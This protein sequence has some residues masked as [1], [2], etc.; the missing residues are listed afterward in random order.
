MK[1]LGLII[2]VS[3]GLSA[4]ASGMNGGTMPGN[5]N[6]IVTQYPIEA[7]M[8][9][10]YTKARSQSLVA[11]VGNQTASADIK[12]TPKGSMVFNNKQVQGAEVNTINKVNNQ[13]TDQSVAINYFTLNPLVFHGFTDS[14]GKYSLSNQTTTIPKMATV[15]SSSKL[16]TEDVYADRSM[17]KK[18]GTY[19]QD[20]SLTRDSNNTAWFC[21]ETSANLLLNNDPNGTSSECYKINARGDILDSKVTI[22]QP[23]VN[24]AKTIVFTSR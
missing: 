23:T 16:I 10:I 4:C 13:I 12:V 11:T 2:A 6:N 22:S 3:I 21:I 8:L 19:N 7:A 20:W 17:R 5:S 18:I 15:G 1:K 14:S 24:G 9:N